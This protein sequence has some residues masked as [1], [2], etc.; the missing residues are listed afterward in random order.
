M[1][2]LNFIFFLSLVAFSVFAQHKIAA[3]E[4]PLPSHPVLVT[5]GTF[6]KIY[7]PS[8]GETKQW[9]INDHTFVMD[10]SGTW[11]LFGITHEEPAN[12]LNE[13]VFAH[14]TS[15]SLTEGPWV[16]QPFAL[17]ADRD[18]WQEV[19]LW[20][21]HVIFI[22]DLYYM[23]YC[24]GAKDHSRYHIHLATSADLNSWER[25]P[26]NPMVVDGFDARDPYILK[27]NDGY[28][29]YY[30]AT[31]NPSGGFHIV[32]CRKSNDLVKWG[33]RQ[34]CYKDPTIGTYGG[35]TESPFVVRRGDVYY[36][37]IGPRP[38]YVGTD[39]FR[40]NTPTHWKPSD[41]VGHIESHAAEVIRDTDGK[42]YISHCGWGQGG[43]YLAPLYWHD[44]L[45][46]APSYPPVPV[47]REKKR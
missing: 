15:P 3:L 2:L 12:P 34:I 25:H 5:A 11:R 35:P 4:K 28:I 26:Q 32:A 24:A 46:D 8:V 30:D 43:V 45:D 14:A 20:A 27:V 39:V 41:L 13:K 9:Y 1:R 16:K 18:N 7:D 17:E 21:P 40:S 47:K 37:F 23:F 42:W 31:D 19:H 38:G 10:S 44:G 6:K 33:K 36:L 29:M 22:N